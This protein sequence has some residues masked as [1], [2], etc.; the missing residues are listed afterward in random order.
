MRRRF[1]YYLLFVAFGLVGCRESTETE[2]PVEVIDRPK[3]IGST[4]NE[5]NTVPEALA[6]NDVVTPRFAGMTEDTVA[7]SL[8]ELL[9][10]QD[11]SRHQLVK[12][13]F[14]A[15]AKEN[16]AL[17]LKLIPENLSF[18]EQ[19]DWAVPIAVGFAKMGDRE[20]AADVLNSLFPSMARV[21]AIVACIQAFS[22]ETSVEDA[23]HFWSSLDQQGTTDRAAGS[24][25]AF[26][27]SRDPVKAI[28]WYETLESRDARR[29]ALEFMVGE[30]RSTIVKQ[31]AIAEERG[32]RRSLASGFGKVLAAEGLELTSALE[33]LQS[34]PADLVEGARISY[35]RGF[36]YTLRFEVEDLFEALEKL[37]QLPDDMISD[38]E[39]AYVGSIIY[40][41]PPSAEVDYEALEAYASRGLTSEGRDAAQ[42]YL[43]LRTASADPTKAVA[44]FVDTGLCE[45][46]AHNWQRVM[47]IWLRSDARAASEYVMKMEAGP[48][49][50]AA[51]ESIINHL[52]EKGD[53]DGADVWKSEVRKKALG[54]G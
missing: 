22:G 18:T 39:S 38:A 1:P 9:I 31:Y 32:L 35:S 43:A 24:L 30:D 29:K 40:K 5:D 8:E 51:A 16:P 47:G 37:A 13:F 19:Q 27:R 50:D 2:S 28:E 21:G 26:L 54:E 15:L 44:M 11:R 52:L 45:R 42:A 33:E 14:E 34:L 46:D 53:Q 48:G 3:P 4:P 20:A 7:S 49:R 17:A 36:G 12:E 10:L 25:A 23:M 6:A 41:Q